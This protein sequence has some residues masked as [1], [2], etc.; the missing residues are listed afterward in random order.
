MY[1]KLA[2]TVLYCTPAYT[3][4]P[5]DDISSEKEEE[6]LYFYH[7]YKRRFYD[8][9]SLKRPIYNVKLDQEGHVVHDE[10]GIPI[11]LVNSYVQGQLKSTK[12]LLYR[13]G[14][15][16]VLKNLHCIE[17]VAGE[18]SCLPGGVNAL[19]RLFNE[20]FVFKGIF[21]IIRAF[22]AQCSLCQV[23]NPL[24]MRVLPPPVPIRSFRPHS[25]LQC[26]LIDMAPKKHRSFMQ[27]NKWGYRYV[28]TVK[29][30]FSKF[31][32]LFPLKTKS[33]EEVYSLL[34]ALFIK[35]GP[36]TI[37]QSDN[38]GE[39]IGEVVQ[40]LCQEFEVGIIHG[41][42][43]H[44]QSQGQIE[45]LNKQVKRLLARFLQRLPRDL[46]ANVWPL[47]L[48][49]VADLLNSKWHSTINDVPFRI[50]KNREPSCLVNYI[51]PDDT[52]WTECIEDGCLQDYEFSFEDFV[53][54]EKNGQSP[55]M[56]RSKLA[57]LA[58]SIVQISS[59]SILL[60]SLG[61]SAKELLPAVKKIVEGHW[62]SSSSEGSSNSSA[63]EADATG[64]F[65]TESVMKY[66][67]NLSEE[68][69]STMINVLE[70]TEH[71]IQKNHKRSLKRAKEREFKVGDKVLF[72]NPCSEGLHFSKPVPFQPLNVVGN[73]KEV[74]PGGM[75]KV[76]CEGQLITKSIFSGQMVLFK[77]KQDV[78]PLPETSP[79]LSLLNLHNFFSD[80]GLTV[81][82]EM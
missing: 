21:N 39:F 51:I 77:E 32:W 1:E 73:M 74:L 6:L 35:E 14:V 18:D 72:Q 58:N 46:Q 4:L 45:N 34:K 66:L 15:E 7:Q 50:Y 22:L 30:C 31:C 76:E 56:D 80:F 33:A 9:R 16:D 49:A 37:I 70:A 24:P 26:D 67:F 17:G 47:L 27:D 28:L 36:P 81:R 55:S 2:E 60:S 3:S 12:Q 68:Y 78:L 64:D 59:E 23:N 57:E 13:E 25:R 40:K 53:E 38:G 42:P 82:K 54:F 5:K 71:T 11:L 69:Q 61:A 43:H 41:R 20:R 65:R 62:T 19:S 10:N 52:M 29:C 75:Y 63:Q 48:S 8:R 44:P 79:K